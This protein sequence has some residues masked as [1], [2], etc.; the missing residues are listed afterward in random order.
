[1]ADSQGRRND[2]VEVQGMLRLLV[3]SEAGF[4]VGSGEIVDLSA[5]GCAIRVGNR[6]IGPN[7]KGR[8]EVRIAGESL[9]LPIVTRWVRTDAHGYLVGCRFEDLTVENLRAVHA[10]IN[11]RQ[12]LFI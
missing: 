10:L 8:I 4:L 11:E 5:G 3:S 7:L 6:S 12:A 9:S 1:M 2:R